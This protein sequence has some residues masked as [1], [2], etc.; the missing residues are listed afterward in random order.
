METYNEENGGE[1]QHFPPAVAPKTIR[2][3]QQNGGVPL[4]HPRRCT[5]HTHAGTPCR[6]YAAR[7]AN[8][9]RVHGGA[10]PQVVAKARERLAL[11]ADTMAKTLLGIASGAESEAVKLAA[12]KDALDRAG[13]PAKAEIAIELKPWEQLM[14]DIAGIATVPSI[15]HPRWPRKP[16]DIYSK[17][18]VFHLT[19]HVVAPLIPTPERRVAGTPRGARTS[20][21]YMV[22]QPHK[23]WLKPVNAL[24]L[25]QIPWQKRC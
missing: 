2:Y 23:W 20:A 11:A 19:I 21:G 5:A 10:A 22:A 3:L 13:V 16:S 6:R 24:H 17:M 9:C 8:V 15:F 12:V 14:S 7:G 1:K 18:G 4:D 25:P